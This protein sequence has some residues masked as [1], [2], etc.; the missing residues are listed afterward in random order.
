MTAAGRRDDSM[1]MQEAGPSRLPMLTSPG[2]KATASHSMT[3]SP[4]SP[5]KRRKPNPISNAIKKETDHAGGLVEDED[6]PPVIV[7]LDVDCFYAQAC[8]IRDP[9]LQGITLGVQQKTLLAAVSYEARAFGVPKFVSI[10]EALRILPTLTIVNGEDL[11]FFRLLSNRNWRLLRSLVWEERVEKCGMDELWADVTEIVD[12]HHL[13]CQAGTINTDHD[14]GI[15]FSFDQMPLDQTQPV[16]TTRGFWYSTK[17][18]VPG[19]F[20]PEP[21]SFKQG[22]PPDPWRQRY[23]LGAYCVAF[24]RRIIREQVNLTCSGG[25]SFSKQMAKLIASANK[26]DKQTCFCPAEPLQ[27]PANGTVTRVD[28]NK[29]FLDDAQAFLDPLDLSKLNG[30]G[31]VYVKKLEEIYRASDPSLLADQEAR[32]YFDWLYSHVDAVKAKQNFTVAIA[33]H[34][35]KPAQFDSLFGS[36]IGPRLWSILHAR[37]P[38]P[39]AVA[40]D[41]AHQISIEDTYRNLQ[42]NAVTAEMRK[43]SESLIKRLE[44][45]CVE[46][47]DEVWL[48]RR[49]QRAVI[50]TLVLP[51]EEDA[52]DKSGGAGEG[53]FFTQVRT[54]VDVEDEEQQATGDAVRA[55]S[56]AAPE[57]VRPKTWRRYP[58]S[59]R[60]SLRIGWAARFSRT[61]R[62]PIGIF[63][64]TQPRKD[65]AQILYN[66]VVG[67]FRQMTAGKDI[68]EGFNLI[69]IAA[70][71]LSKS[72]PAASDIK[73]ML[74]KANRSPHV[75]VPAGTKG[76]GQSSVPRVEERPS[77]DLG[78]LKELPPDI[79]A[80]VAQEYGIEWP[81]LTTPPLLP[82]A[83]S[84]PLNE[85]EAVVHP[86]HASPMA[87]E[88]TAS[89]PA[90][91]ARDEWT[92][93]PS[94][95]SS[96]SFP[97][98]QLTAQ[99]FSPPPRSITSSP[100]LPNDVD[101]GDDEE[102]PT[103]QGSLDIGN[104]ADEL[105]DV[106]GRE[107][108]Q[109]DPGLDDLS[110][111][112]SRP[113]SPL[114][115]SRDD[116]QERP[117]PQQRKFGHFEMSGCE[118]DA[119]ELERLLAPPTPP[120]GPLS[121]QSAVAID[122][123]EMA[124]ELPGGVE[125][126][127]PSPTRSKVLL[128]HTEANE[129]TDHN[130][131]AD[132]PKLKTVPPAVPKIEWKEQAC[133]HCGRP[134]L[135]WLQHDH[136]LFGESGLPPGFDKERLWGDNL[137]F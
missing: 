49:Q 105:G 103:R 95:P 47:P 90:R 77:I 58:L 127:G 104:S 86:N 48:A 68:T 135:A 46:L 61:G 50:Q 63:D 11:S 51:D 18:P 94:S 37:D 30:F 101:R 70:L 120:L 41:F 78:T 24:F 62:M 42:G 83:P 91:P 81:P 43:L 108:N 23:A 84:S 26:P 132:A 55:E 85:R 16:D 79:A 130:D 8:R 122:A 111:L 39:V 54:Y 106:E 88:Q 126:S 1:A 10:R 114:A 9:S 75:D 17:D 36:T 44:V 80:E 21:H 19:F 82:H 66:T 6:L 15:F 89:S 32:G 113:P 76:N 3:T 35:F 2:S 102:K 56:G 40:S 97:P 60:L 115:Q 28:F 117:E 129:A 112:G 5:F 98:S 27:P 59:V 57:P 4:G 12:D 119:D 116:F 45:E 92:S 13:R 125:N 22:W 99:S 67:I 25:V 118:M 110:H 136:D 33:R 121:R 29:R 14:L 34:F 71:E 93:P 74:S 124:V 123:T 31:H 53:K 137:P 133:G 38:E 69:N 96:C 87:G 64:L 72:P 20:L 65:R 73:K 131:S 107:M 128:V 100:P 109:G 134:Q 7:A 52:A